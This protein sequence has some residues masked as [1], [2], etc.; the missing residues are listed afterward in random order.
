M[1]DLGLLTYMNLIPLFA[2]PYQNSINSSFVMVIWLPK[3]QYITDLN[4]CLS[5]Q[6]KQFL[7]SCQKLF[8]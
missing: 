3:L 8:E 4:A 7:T 6:L 2:K 5:S 1:I